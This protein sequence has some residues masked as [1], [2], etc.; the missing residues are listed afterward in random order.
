MR[1]RRPARQRR[2]E[3]GGEIKR[4]LEIAL[5][6]SNAVETFVAGDNAASYSRRR[7]GGGAGAAEA[8]F[9]FFASIWP[10]AAGP[11]TFGALAL[12]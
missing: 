7:G 6:T 10:S 1:P 12:D 4:G 9:I 3:P 8:G 2:R 11:G 5:V